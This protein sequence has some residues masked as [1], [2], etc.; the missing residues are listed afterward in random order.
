MRR[1]LAIACGIVATVA[2]ITAQDG[3]LHLIERF[4]RVSPEILNYEFTV[5]DPTLWTRP[6]TA[7]I[8]LRHK[9]ELIYEYACHEANLAIPDMLAGHRFEEREAAK[10]R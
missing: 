1:V 6:W 8:P 3:W 9:D 2:T 4:T 5:D 10:K 7:M